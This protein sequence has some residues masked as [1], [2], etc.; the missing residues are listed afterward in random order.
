MVQPGT[1]GGTPGQ[2]GTPGVPGTPGTPG[3]SWT[4]MG[5]NP[6]E[7]GTPYQEADRLPDNIQV[8]VTSQDN[9]K[10][11]IVEVLPDGSYD[12]QFLDAVQTVT[13]QYQELE[14]VRPVKK[15][16]VVVISGPEKNAVGTLIGIDGT[17]GIVKLLSNSDIRILELGRV[18]KLAD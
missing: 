1:P 16:R 10:G 6:Y 9:R 18:A 4:P 17:D 15:D 5:D 7:P 8:Q 2:P 13:V 14:L 11:K 3:G 12:V